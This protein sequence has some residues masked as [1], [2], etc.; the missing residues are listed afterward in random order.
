MVEGAVEPDRLVVE[1]C[2]DGS[3]GAVT[4][5][6]RGRETDFLAGA[7]GGVILSEYTKYPN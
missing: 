4:E 1:V 3:F 7:E 6:E 5:E 2:K